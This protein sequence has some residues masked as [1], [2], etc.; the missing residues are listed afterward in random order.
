MH[1]RFDD[2]FPA[3]ML[4]AAVAVVLAGIWVLSHSIEKARHEPPSVQVVQ[5]SDLPTEPVPELCLESEPTPLLEPDYSVIPMDKPIVDA[6]VA[7]CEEYG[8]P[9]SLALGVIEV[10]SG[11]Q[12]DAVSAEG[13]YGLCQLN[14]R[15]FPEDLLPADNI[16]CGVQYLGELLSR[17]GDTAVALTIY[18]SGWDTGDRTYAEAVLAAAERWERD[19]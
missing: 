11:F 15:Y 4:A 5:T 13:C 8:V 18:N 6:L 16:R 17:H 2:I 14:P 10:E 7:S 9:L 12:V 19:G 3:L 1:K